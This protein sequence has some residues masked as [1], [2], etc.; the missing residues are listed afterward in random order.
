MSPNTQFPASSTIHKVGFDAKRAFTNTSGLG[1]YS[2]HIISSLMRFY[3]N[4]EYTLFT[5]GINPIFADFYPQTTHCEIVKP[6]GLSKKLAS[7]WRTFGMADDLSKRKIDL[8]H[9][10]SNELPF[11]LSDTNTKL[12]VTIHDLI[13]LRYPSWYNLTDRFIYKKKFANACRIADQI[14]AISEQTKA[15][16][17]QFF[18]TPAEKISVVYQDCDPVFQIP[19][20]GAELARIRTQYQLPER[21]I[22]CVGTIEKRKNQLNLLKAWHTSNFFTNFDLVLVGKHTPYIK[23]VKQYI[24]QHG[25]ES[26]VH[27]PPYIPFKDLPGLYRLASLFV[28]PSVF[29]G[30]GIPIIEAL[31]CGV[32]VITSTGSCFS[33]AGGPGSI[34]INPESAEELTAAI[35]KVLSSPELQ[36]QMIPQGKQHVLQFRPE[37]TIDKLHQVY[38]KA[39]NL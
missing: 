1:N 35:N 20:P 22:L 18:G 30:F 38:K 16:I 25:L 4:E 33:E 7:V 2:R 11:G 8:Y 9:G 34:Y 12:V 29:E 10:L 37:N 27:F 19:M 31:N 14:V 36:R 39:L 23:E 21:Y 24:Q 13:F 26:R 15:D 5:T 32:P 17:I 6:T 28:Y 3:P